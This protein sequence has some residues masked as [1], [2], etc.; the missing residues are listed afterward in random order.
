MSS[1]TEIILKLKGPL[2]N[3]KSEPFK[4][5]TALELTPQ[6]LSQSTQK[7]IQDI[8]PPSKLGDI[9]SSMIMANITPKDG[10]QAVKLHRWSVKINNKMITDKSELH[11]DENQLK[12]L[13]EIFTKNNIKVENSA[14]LGAIIYHLQQKEIE[15]N[16][17]LNPETHKIENKSQ[18]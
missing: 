1:N 6:Q 7:H 13:I 3:Y 16:N 4:D 5:Y 11:L 10:D 14:L 2:L 18:N 9:M 17:K 12:E 15:L 8:A